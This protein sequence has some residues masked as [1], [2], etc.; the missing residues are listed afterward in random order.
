M[1]I[2]KIA[3]E[4]FTEKGWAYINLPKE[5]KK[6]ILAL[7]SEIDEEDLY[8]EEADGGYEK[9]PHITVKYGFTTDDVKGAKEVLKGEKK[10]IAMIL[11]ADYF[12]GEEYDVVKLTV[13][14]EDLERIHNCFCKLP[15]EDQFIHYNAHI[16]IAYVKKGKGKKYKGKF[17]LDKPFEFKEV[18]YNGAGSEKD[19]KI[20]LVS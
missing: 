11:G 13:S 9:E 16:T 19:I 5:I 20:N 2:I 8:V 10:G 15:H 4:V 14:S 12:N 7:S 3:K 17:N 18:Y 6:E 1:E